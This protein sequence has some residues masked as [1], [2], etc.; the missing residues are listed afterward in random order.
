MD[1]LPTFAVIGAGMQGPAIAY[2]LGRFGN[3]ARIF[4]ADIDPT[5]ARAQSKRVNLLLER[6]IV[7]PL[8]LNAT[9]RDQVAALFEQS[10]IVISAIPTQF[11]PSLALFALEAKKSFCDLGT[12]SEWFWN[13][14]RLLSPRAEDA[15]ISIVPNCGLAPGM[16]SHIGLYLMETLSECDEIRLFCGGLPQNPRP[17]LFYETVFNI[18]GLLNEYSGEALTL[19]EGQ[20]VR[21]PAMEDVETLEI[22]AL[23]ILEAAATSG[24]IGTLPFTL[25]GKVLNLNYKTL[26]YPGHWAHFRLIRDIGFLERKPLL[27]GTY[28]I[29]PLEVTEKVLE[30]H[31]KRSRVA[32]IVV[33]HARASGRRDSQRCTLSVTIVDRA[34][35]PTGFSAMERMTG[36]STS[37]IAIGIAEGRVPCGIIPYEQTMSGHDFVAEF[38]RRGFT[39]QETIS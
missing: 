34:D 13:E 29:I 11:N 23:G 2:D 6:A 9:E 37:I 5:R 14:F 3:P 32:D 18:G 8:T 22:P 17:P 25:Q 31:F 30:R 39:L 38:R 15:G 19:Q 20:V 1:H 4:L 7:E 16:V 10:D 36:F 27:V 12:D 21:V 26:R 24:S 35:E 28:P 33:V